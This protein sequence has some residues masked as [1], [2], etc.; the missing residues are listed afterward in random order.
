MALDIAS[1]IIFLAMIIIYLVFLFYDALGREEPYGNYVYIVAIIPVSYLWY[2]I[3]LPVNRTDFESFGVIGVWSI[4]LILWYVSIIRDI[5][6]IKKKKK[7]ID[8]VALYLII[9]V[10]IQLIAC[11]VLPAPN[12]VPTMNYWI[13]KFLFFYVPDFNIAISSQLIWLN[14]F[15]LFMTLIVIT[16]IIPLVTD[17][18]GTYVNLWVVIILTLIFSL[19][20]GLICWIWIPEAW[21]ALLFLVDVLFF[22]VL[23]MLTRGKDKK[24]NK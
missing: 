23:L 16:V 10:I 7:E 2:L 22:I 24:K 9:G 6:L 18:K 12:V 17:L 21:G 15:R 4:L 5:I 19:P 11:S 20:F 14:I 3:T 8:D 1:I 13:T